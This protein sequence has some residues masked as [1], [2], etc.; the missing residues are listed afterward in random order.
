MKLM[1]AFK[2]GA[3]VLGIIGGAV[4]GFI[5]GGALMGP[6]G[7]F[8]GALTGPMVG[9]TVALGAVNCI[10]LALKSYAKRRQTKWV[11]TA[12]YSTSIQSNQ[13][14]TSSTVQA[15]RSFG[16]SGNASVLNDVIANVSDQNVDAAHNDEPPTQQIRQDPTVTDAAVYS[17][18][19]TAF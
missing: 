4:A 14:R 10:E 17:P 7:A 9:L 5:L 12:E 13:M 16:K 3:G 2:I 15:L 19:A 18:G 1:T 8:A 11:A 6:A